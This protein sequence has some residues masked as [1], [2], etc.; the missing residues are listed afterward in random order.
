MHWLAANELSSLSKQQLH[1]KVRFNSPCSREVYRFTRHAIPP[2]LT[3]DYI[4]KREAVPPDYSVRDTG[5]ENFP[6]EN[7]NFPNRSGSSPYSRR[8][9]TG[10][11]EYTATTIRAFERLCIPTGHKKEEKGYAKLYGTAKGIK[12]E[13]EEE[14]EEDTRRK[15]SKRKE[16][17]L[18]TARSP[19][20]R[21]EHSRVN[22]SRQTVWVRVRER[23]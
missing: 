20:P 13:E 22:Q 11:F 17:S 6:Q 5:N 1:V 4:A 8:E 12:E 10:I 16:Q 23:R 3:R 18:A 15:T 19:T 21:H 9:R 2:L 7:S 14:E